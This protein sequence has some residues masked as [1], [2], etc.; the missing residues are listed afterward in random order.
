[1]YFSP[2]IHYREESQRVNTRE[3]EISRNMPETCPHCREPGKCKALILFRNC[4]EN[5]GSARTALMRSDQVWRW[6][7]TAYVT[8]V[9]RVAPLCVHTDFLRSPGRNRCAR[10][11]S[12]RGRRVWPNGGWEAVAADCS[13]MPYRTVRKIDRSV[14]GG[15]KAVRAVD[16]YGDVS[17]LVVDQF[18]ARSA[19]P[20]GV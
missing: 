12:V 2:D 13:I 1:L 5:W 19:V 6:D 10:P 15:T 9:W 4:F 17:I 8:I 3:A 11:G 14:V 20:T 7:V 18:C 16:R